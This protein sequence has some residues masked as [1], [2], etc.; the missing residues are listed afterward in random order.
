VR[1][2]PSTPTTVRIAGVIV[3]LQG[4]VGVV[5]AVMLLVQPG[6][7]SV[8]DRLGEAGFFALMA[9]A[10]TGF[11]IAL[12]LGK[13]GARSPAVLVELLLIGIAAYATVPSKQPLYGIPVAVLC[14]FV[15]Y[16]LL[17]P[18]A[19]DWVTD[20]DTSDHHDPD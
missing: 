15:L 10:V 17:N 11:G 8:T 1:G 20:R 16:L 6:V 19:R 13:R 14:V 2:D 7:L 18:G 5:V 3:G 9:A 12:V 4:L